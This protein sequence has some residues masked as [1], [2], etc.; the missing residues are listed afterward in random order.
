MHRCIS[1]ARAVFTGLLVCGVATCV[2][3]QN[4]RPLKGHLSSAITNLAP[5][6]RMESARTLNLAIGVPLRDPEGLDRFLADIYDPT[7]PN[8]RHYL[9]PEQFTE[10]FGATEA[11]YQKVVNFARANGLTVIGTH[12]DHM[13]LD[14]SGPVSAI[15]KAFQI[16]MQVYPH[17][18]EKRDF[19][20]PD[21]EPSVPAG[22]PIQDIC[23]LNNYEPPR[24]K[25]LKPVPVPLRNGAK[26]MVTGSGPGGLFMGNDFRAAYAPGVTWTGA[27][28]S[29]GMLEFDGYYAGDITA[30][31]NLAGLPHVPL[32]IVLTDMFDGTPTPPGPNSGNG[33]VALDIEMAVSMAP[34]LSSI[35]LYEAGTNGIGNDV[36]SAMSTNTTISQF[37]S[38]WTFGLNPR[39]TMDTYF[40][41]LQSQG[42][43]FFMASGDTGA[44]TGSVPEPCDDPYVTSVGGMTLST[45]GPGGPWLAEST[46]NTGDGYYMSSG[47]I[48]VT[49]TNPVW[50][51]GLSVTANHGSLTKRNLPDVSMVADNIL[52]VADE[53]QQE[54]TGGTSASAQL[55]AAFVALANQE[56]V[57]NGLPVVGFIN[58]ATYA[59]GKSIAFNAAFVDI[60]VNNNTNTVA[61]QFPAVA[62]YDL[63]TGWGVPSGGSMLIAL[64]QPDGFQAIP[65]K[66]VPING[67][68]GGPFTFATE[69]LT[70]TNSGTGAFSWSL[71]NTSVW[72]NVS[73]TSG[74]L[75]P[76]GPAAAV[77]LSLN[78]A[79][80]KLA[81]GNY[82]ANVWL[83]N[84]TSKLVQLRQVVLQV[85]QELVQ[86]GGFEDGDFAYWILFGPYAADQNFADDGTAYNV[87]PFSGDYFAD[88]G[89]TNTLDFL[90]QVLPTRVGQE[91]V[92]RFEWQC[93]D[94]GYGTTPNQFEVKWN[95]TTLTNVVNIGAFGWQQKQFIVQGTT[96]NTTLEFAFRIDP[97]IFGLDAVSVQAI[98]NPNF[99]A[100]SDSGGK[101]QLSYN[102]IPGFAYQ[103]QYKTNL[104]STNW[105]N[106]GSRTNA[107]ST[108]VSTSDTIGTNL[109]RFYRVVMT[110]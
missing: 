84:N 92:L 58:P 13:L 93:A 82:V 41:K 42:Q 98:G 95:S 78:P 87:L 64:A 33:E 108:T 80:N 63:C 91:Y 50:Q 71:S 16:R 6:G 94:L 37:A 59:I 106:L 3:A 34:G 48:S 40:K 70:L 52:E 15:E 47:G 96:T 25:Y 46:W 66:P 100:V 103:L 97:G 74:T 45:A 49:Y 11:D 26:P 28:Q 8:Y 35:V 57:A 30:Y 81:A 20:A 18:T 101:V 7:S 29:I 54:A 4:W 51:Q 107:T 23:G 86:D 39:T 2:T 105:V 36:L 56:A 5:A 85:G 12:S 88:L 99:Q 19:F 17:P 76:G 53:G 69:T 77:T 60:T 22:V 110:L 75:T 65:G 109:Q 55:Y 1:T 44:Y 43:S 62:G 38:S 72:L 61:S 27:G 79:A 24:P 73:Q 9:T 90:A 89:S 67:P 31:E 14:V 21:T 83:T 32:Q 68:V 104:I 10:K 102:T